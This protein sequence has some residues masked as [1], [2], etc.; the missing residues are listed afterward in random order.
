M[1]ACLAISLYRYPGVGEEDC[2][3]ARAKMLRSAIVLFTEFIR[4]L[5]LFLFLLSL[6]IADLIVGI[7][8]DTR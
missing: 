5:F 7:F 4:F 2:S 3:V 8:C 1:A 6:F